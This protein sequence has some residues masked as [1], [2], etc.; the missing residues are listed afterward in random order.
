MA[1]VRNTKQP[2]YDIFQYVFTTTNPQNNITTKAEKYYRI[3]TQ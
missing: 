1:T 2:L 3:V